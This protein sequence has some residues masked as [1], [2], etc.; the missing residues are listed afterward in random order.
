MVTGTPSQ[1]ERMRQKIAQFLEQ[2]PENL[3]AISYLYNNADQSDKE[4]LVETMCSLIN[5]KK[6]SKNDERT[7][8]IP[9]RWPKKAS[10]F[11]ILIRF[12]LH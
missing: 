7:I 2:H 3:A 11:L 1:K 12:H 9:K 8:Y 6:T 10:F 5:N 4:H